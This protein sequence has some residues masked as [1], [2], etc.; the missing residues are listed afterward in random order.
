MFQALNCI[1]TGGPAPILPTVDEVSP[2]TWGIFMQ[3]DATSMTIL[4]KSSW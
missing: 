2:K 1:I 4:P 3:I